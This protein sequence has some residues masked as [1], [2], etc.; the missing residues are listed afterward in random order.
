MTFAIPDDLAPEV[1][2]LAW[3]LGRWRGPGFLAYPDIPERP[4][5][6]ETEFTHDG[7]P[8]LA[9]ASTTWLLDGELAGLDRPFDPEALAAGQL[10]AAESG[11]WRPV[12]GGPRRSAFGVVQEGSDTRTEPGGAEPDPAGRR[13]PS[14][15]V[16]VLLA[17]P[18]GH[19]SVFVGSVRGP[20]IDLATDLVARTSTAAEVTAATR[21]YGLVQ[22]DL[23]WATDLAAFGHEMQ[24]YSSGRLAR[25]A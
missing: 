13:A 25:M 17:E 7:G 10:W 8:Y 11:Y 20:R 18:S 1:Y 14:T 19:V 22:G 2:P 3:L 15:E 9:Y 5:V 4:V 23:M 16:E 24:S 21:M 6:V 12:V